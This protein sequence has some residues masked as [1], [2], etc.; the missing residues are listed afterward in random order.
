MTRPTTFPSG[1]EL[2]E[3]LRAFYAENIQCPVEAITDD[4]DLEADLGVDSLTQVELLDA[5]LLRYGLSEVGRNI[6]PGAY[7]TLPDLAKLFQR[8]YES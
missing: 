6:R 2:L 5:A 8:L 7:P 1:E 4:T 3:Q